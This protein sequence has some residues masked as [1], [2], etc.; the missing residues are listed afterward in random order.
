MVKLVVAKET[1]ADDA[2]FT[3]RNGHCCQK[4]TPERRVRRQRQPMISWRV[5]VACHSGGFGGEIRALARSRNRDHEALT[6][7]LLEKNMS[8]KKT[9]TSA[10]C[11]KQAL[12][13][14]PVTLS[15]R[16]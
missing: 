15:K 10:S 8:P 1:Q 11:R 16:Q 4:P 3:T 6:K 12:A 13:G 14:W 5:I 2:P 9:L 7:R